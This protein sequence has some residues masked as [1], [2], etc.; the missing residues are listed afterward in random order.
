MSMRGCSAWLTPAGAEAAVP[1]SASPGVVAGHPDGCIDGGKVCR[2]V[3]AYGPKRASASA[4]A[5]WPASAAM[6]AGVRPS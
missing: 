5:S 6:S 2:S 4:S 1:P 3:A